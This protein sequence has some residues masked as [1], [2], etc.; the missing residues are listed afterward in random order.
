[1]VQ[2]LEVQ[3]ISIDASINGCP[4]L[5]TGTVEALEIFA[6]VDSLFSH[7][8][9][10]TYDEHR[11]GTIWTGTRVLRAS[12]LP[13]DLHRPLECRQIPGERG[14]GKRQPLKGDS[15]ASET[16]R[17]QP[18]RRSQR[19]LD[20]PQPAQTLDP[21]QIRR[22]IYVLG[23]LPPEDFG[24]WEQLVYAFHTDATLQET[25]DDILRSAQFYLKWHPSQH[26]QGYAA[27]Q[28]IP[29][30]TRLCYY[31]G[32]LQILLMTASRSNH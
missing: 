20:R 2:D 11:S 23:D 5:S 19:L 3:D 16:A 7:M 25:V 27:A 15:F 28:D 21:A 17:Q 22:T 12:S 29:K 8:Y 4:H 31:S 32:E 30:G 9:D 10:V 24:E 26:G 14:G 6:A 13:I 1:M 18:T